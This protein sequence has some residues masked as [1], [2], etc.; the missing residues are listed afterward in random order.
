MSLVKSYR[1]LFSVSVIAIAIS[2]ISGALFGSFGH[3]G[4]V[5]VEKG[6]AEVERVL[7]K[8]ENTKRYE[9]MGYMQDDYHSWEYTYS[10]V[11]W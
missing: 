3:S 2:L 4:M 7:G 6:L 11:N 5:N 10:Q 8:K 1:S 9:S